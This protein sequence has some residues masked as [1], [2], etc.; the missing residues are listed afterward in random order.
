MIQIILSLYLREPV[1]TEMTIGN[2]PLIK[3]G[4][5]MA[6]DVSIVS[7]Q[8][9]TAAVNVTTIDAY[10]VTD[11][12]DV[13]QQTMATFFVKNT[14]SNPATVKLIISPDDVYYTDDGGEVAVPVGYMI[15]LQTSIYSRYARVAYKSAAAG[16]PTTLLIT[17]QGL[18]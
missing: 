9:T 3:G 4:K 16:N 1:I 11:V 8:F 18:V 13:S 2:G 17:F 5:L 10:S 7:S 12:Y 14:G 15:P 6:I